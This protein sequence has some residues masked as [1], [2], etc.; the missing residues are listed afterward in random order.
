MFLGLMNLFIFS[1]SATL[2][3]YIHILSYN[4]EK[5]NCCGIYFFKNQSKVRYSVLL[6]LYKT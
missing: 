4:L 6:T 3:S 5:V 2:K 1:V